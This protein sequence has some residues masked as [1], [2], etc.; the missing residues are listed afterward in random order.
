M[1]GPAIF[2]GG[3]VVRNGWRFAVEQTRIH[4]DGCYAFQ[5]DGESFSDVIVFATKL[6]P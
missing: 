2:L 3:S 4:T 6:Q 5:I 1:S